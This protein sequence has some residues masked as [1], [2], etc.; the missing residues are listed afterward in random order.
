M[1]VFVTG[2]SGYIGTAVVQELINAGHQVVG[3]ARSEESAKIISDAGAEVLLGSLE[4]LQI[5]QEGASQADGVIHTAFIHDFTQYLKAGEVDKAAINAMSEVLQGTDKPLVVTSGMLAL[6]QIDGFIREESSAA[7]SPRTS[8]A[9]ILELVKEKGINGSII[10]IPPSCHDKG[11]KGFIPFIIAQ[12]LKNGVSAY[13]EDGTNQW[14]S[15][16]RL[17][18]AKAFR[19]AVEKAEKG[20]VYNVVGDQGIETKKIA[21]LIGQKLNLPV[22]SLSGD[23]LTVHFDWMSLFITFD[24]RANGTKTEEL[25]GWK[26]THIGLLQ[27]MEENYF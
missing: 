18:A 17:D 4:D 11:D 22:R 12:A 25:L 23:V 26:P 21:E 27:D 20:A 5:L 3:L 15:V 14:S 6:P 19:L 1:K 24:A 10:R 9:S 16:H 8:E 7:H 2:A 13:P